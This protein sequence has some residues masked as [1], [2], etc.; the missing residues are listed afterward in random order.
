MKKVKIIN[1]NFDTK[2][3]L[4][5]LI[6]I[7]IA[8]CIIAYSFY[9][10]C[11]KNITGKNDILEEKLNFTSI[12]SYEANYNVLVN[13]NKNSNM[14]NVAESVDLLDNT[15]DYLVDDKL[16]ITI[17][18]DEI[19]ISK[20]GIAYEYFTKLNSNIENNNFVSFSSIIE[21][22]KKINNSELKGNIKKVEINNNT[23][24]K[25]HLEDEYIKKIKDIEIIMSDND[26]NLL[27]IKMYNLDGNE[28]YHLIFNDF[29]VKK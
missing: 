13:S 26:K 27:E 6:S 3:K 24:Y 20:E 29:K 1:L 23:V 18:N 21:I 15:Y 25:I 8:I 16:K 19:K 17:K 2:T 12:N 10:I 28:Q 14:Y 7:I 5:M 11:I 4:V 9:T 22:V